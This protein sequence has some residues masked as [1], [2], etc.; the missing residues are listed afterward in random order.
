MNMDNLDAI[1][2][3]VPTE[4]RNF[5]VKNLDAEDVIDELIQERIMGQSAAQR[6][7]LAGT[8][9]VEKNQYKSYPVESLASLKVIQ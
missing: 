9:R 1:Q 3:Q 7:Q 5:I 2:D 8:S 4:N 6:V